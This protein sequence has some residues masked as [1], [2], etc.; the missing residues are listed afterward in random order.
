MFPD[1]EGCV[2]QS[3]YLGF[4]VSLHNEEVSAFRHLSY[5]LECLKLSL[6]LLLLPCS[7]CFLAFGVKA[8]EPDE[9]EILGIAA[10]RSK[11]IVYLLSAAA[12]LDARC[13]FG[14]LSKLEVGF[15]CLAQVESGRLSVCWDPGLLV[16][17]CQLQSIVLLYQ[18]LCLSWKVCSWAL[19]HLFDR[20]LLSKAA[21]QWRAA[22]AWGAQ[23]GWKALHVLARSTQRGF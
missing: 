20:R 5:A 16:L 13:L 10:V 12:S 8:S 14:R 21:C 22:C 15:R 23:P 6:K 3:S 9:D 7:H 18:A 2:S 11:P 19:A 17:P 4:I 1:F